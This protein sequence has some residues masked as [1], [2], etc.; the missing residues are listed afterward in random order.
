MDVA[1]AVARGADVCFLDVREAVEWDEGHI[2]GSVHIPIS[3][4]ESRVAELEKDR[5]IVVVCQ[6][7]QR[8][9]LVCGFLLARGF[10]AHNLDGGLEAWT[11][12]GHPL[13]AAGEAPGRLVDGWARGLTGERLDGQPG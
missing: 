11:G 3:A 8:S 9:L 4:V 1:T 2:A 7:G 13:V 12:A 6:I 10:D 5:P